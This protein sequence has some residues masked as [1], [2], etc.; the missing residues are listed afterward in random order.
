MQDV[1]VD[2][3]EG[4]LVIADPGMAWAERYVMGLYVSTDDADGFSNALGLS[5]S[6]DD[7]DDRV[8]ARCITDSV[9]FTLG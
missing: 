5:I 9:D 8:V 7:E 6:H 2:G 4:R 3:F 1:T